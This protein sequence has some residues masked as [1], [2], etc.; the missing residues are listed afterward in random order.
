MVIFKSFKAP[1]KLKTERTY[2]FR[3]G[4]VHYIDTKSSNKSDEHVYRAL[5]VTV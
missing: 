2:E 3:Q 5:S 1:Y 4:I